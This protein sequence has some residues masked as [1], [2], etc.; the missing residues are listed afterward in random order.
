MRAFLIVASL[1]V[2][3]AVAIWARGP[4][5]QTPPAQSART[6]ID[7]GLAEDTCMS[8][9]QSY[10][11]NLHAKRMD[12]FFASALNGLVRCQAY[13]GLAHVPTSDITRWLARANGRALP[14]PGGLKP[15]L[16]KLPQHEDERLP[17]QRACTAYMR[18]YLP[19]SIAG[20]GDD[21]DVAAA[22]IFDALEECDSAAGFATIAPH[23]LAAIM[24]ANHLL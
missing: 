7:A 17:Y 13:G 22:F 15:F 8:Q 16:A 4:M 3:L 18:A 24:Q 12:K 20:A 21:P 11:T 6:V 10:L 1:A 19:K 5:H 14:A 2:V 9:L 23:D